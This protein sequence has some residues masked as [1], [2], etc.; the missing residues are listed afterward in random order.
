MVAGMCVMAHKGGL[1]VHEV[2]RSARRALASRYSAS[3]A[4]SNAGQ[5]Q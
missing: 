2:E 1:D 5:D 3:A 4:M